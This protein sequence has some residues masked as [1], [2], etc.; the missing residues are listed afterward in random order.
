MRAVSGL[1]TKEVCGF[2]QENPSII[3]TCEEKQIKCL[4]LSKGKINFWLADNCTRSQELS[5][6]GEFSCIDRV[7]MTEQILL[8][9]TL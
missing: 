1:G 8:I 3:S 9:Q 4:M 6:I 2:P 5:V 7:V